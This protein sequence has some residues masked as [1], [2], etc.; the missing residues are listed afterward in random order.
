[1]KLIIIATAMRAQVHDEY[2]TYSDSGCMKVLRCFRAQP[3]REN[4]V[5]LIAT[6]MQTQ[7][8]DDNTYVHCITPTLDE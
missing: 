8:H 1:M 3:I 2:N 5:K 7:V 6:P 4:N